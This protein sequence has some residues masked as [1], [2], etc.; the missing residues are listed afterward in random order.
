MLKLALFSTHRTPSTASTEDAGAL[1]RL[2]YRAG[3]PVDDYIARLRGDG[4]SATT[5]A[6]IRR[7]A[8]DAL[9][10]MIP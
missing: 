10:R 5:L 8:N 4:Y 1:F 3:E 7:L 9:W 6:T 2:T